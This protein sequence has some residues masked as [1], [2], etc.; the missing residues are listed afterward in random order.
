MFSDVIL[1]SVRV[2]VLGL[3]LSIGLATSTR[4][5][6]TVLSGRIEGSCHIEALD[7]CQLSFTSDVRHDASTPIIAARV[8]ANGVVIH[9]YR[10]DAI[11]PTSDLE[12]PGRTVGGGNSTARC[13][14]TYILVLQAQAS[15]DVEF[16]S[17]AS[18]REIPCPVSV[19]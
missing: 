6:A 17:P 8:L 14:Q 18:T 5:E 12:V 19:P 3:G 16:K 7:E 1:P 9:E 13:G 4:A 10:N 2:M 11:N 15:D